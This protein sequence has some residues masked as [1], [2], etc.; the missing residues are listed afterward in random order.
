[1]KQKFLDQY[2]HLTR[3]MFVLEFLNGHSLEFYD[4][5]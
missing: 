1:M 4:L 3:G 5:I 2:H